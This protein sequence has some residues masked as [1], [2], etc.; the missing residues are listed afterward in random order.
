MISRM[1]M[2]AANAGSSIPPSGSNVYVVNEFDPNYFAGGSVTT[3][4]RNLTSGALN[5]VSNVS[6]I[7]ANTPTEIVL[8]YDGKNAYA[9]EH[10]Q[11]G[12]VKVFD[13]DLTDGILTFASSIAA[14]TLSFGIGISP[15]DKNVYVT[16]FY[17]NT[18][19]V[20]TRNLSTGT[21][22]FLET[23]TTGS[24]PKPV[25]ISPDGKNVYVKNDGDGTVSIFDRNLT[26]GA[27]TGSS[28]LYHSSRS[29]GIVISPD[30]KNI[31]IADRDNVSVTII[32]R[33]VSD[34]SLSIASTIS[35]GA[36]TI[37][38]GITISPDGKN[39]Y[40]TLDENAINIGLGVFTRD[41]STGVLSGLTF[42][43]ST[44]LA[45]PARIKVS[46]DNKNV[47]MTNLGIDI[48]SVFDRNISTG[49]LT[50]ASTL[51][52]GTSP[53]GLAVY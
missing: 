46:S 5:Q 22:T 17:G 24:E 40:V 11:P 42:M 47:Y 13:R 27:L 15:D 41:L 33:D 3:Y 31:Y 38:Y 29:D 52:T 12:Y 10:G 35:T 16:G 14:G 50:L 19:D 18:L 36:N 28:Y 51:A 45:A 8:S 53:Q 49:A 4:N 48:L 43:P 6:T 20:F 44:S 30:G 37:P 25:A 21:L 32:D 1:L 39:V 2:M 34:G 7:G 26:S 23:I 9:I